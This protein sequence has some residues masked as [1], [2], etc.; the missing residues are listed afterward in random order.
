[1]V[2][3]VR[4][5]LGAG[6]GFDIAPTDRHAL[7]RVMAIALEFAPTNVFGRFQASSRLPQNERA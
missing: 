6:F 7:L 3:V 5:R 1:M 4:D 2:R